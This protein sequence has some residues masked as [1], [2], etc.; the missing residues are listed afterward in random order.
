MLSYTLNVYPFPNSPRV[1]HVPT[2]EAHTT[3]QDGALLCRH[4]CYPT[5]GT[6]Q[7]P[8]S[9][10]MHTPPSQTPLATT[11]QSHDKTITTLDPAQAFSIPVKDMEGCTPGVL[12]HLWG[13]QLPSPET[14]VPCTP[15]QP[16]ILECE[17]SNNPD[18]AFV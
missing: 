4:I 6:T 2:S 8:H 3:F 17:L 18:K 16:L 9:F 1:G 13:I 7:K 14:W 15:Q 11:S 10:L 12:P 5:L